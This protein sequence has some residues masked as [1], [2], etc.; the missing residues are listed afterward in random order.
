MFLDWRSGARKFLR[1]ELQVQIPSPPF[2]VFTG[3]GPRV[4]GPVR[5]LTIP[6]LQELHP[7]T[8]TVLKILL[9]FKGFGRDLGDY[10]YT[11]WMARLRVSLS[12][13]SLPLK[14]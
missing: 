14:G 8:R 12:W 9:R 4:R 11:K 2:R 5:K 1:I 10:A 13:H 6:R 7:W 3:R